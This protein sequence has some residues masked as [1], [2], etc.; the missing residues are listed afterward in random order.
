MFAALGVAPWLEDALRRVKIHEPT[1]IQRLAIPPALEGRNIIGTAK[2]GSGKT[3][4]Y[5]LPILQKLSKDP[6][7]VFCLVLSP[8]RELC[9]QISDQF[10]ALGKGCKINSV[11]VV[12]GRDQTQQELKISSRPHVVVATPGR[13]AEILRFDPEGLKKVFRN[14]QVVVFDEADRILTPTFEPELECILECLPPAS[15]RQTMLFSATMTESLRVLAEKQLTNVAIVDATNQDGLQANR[16]R[17][18]YMHLPSIVKRVYLHHLLHSMEPS[19]GVII[20]CSTVESTQ[21]ITTMCEMLGFQVACLHSLQSQ[22]RRMVSL[23]KF[24]GESVN[25]LIATDVA[26]RGLDIPA[27]QRVIN[28]ELPDGPD[29]YMHRVGRTARAGR[30]GEAITF[31]SE[32]DEQKIERIEER[33]ETKLELF[34]SKEEEVLKLM[35]KTTKAYQKAQLLLFEVGF[36]EKLKEWKEQKRR[37]RDA[38]REAA[39]EKD[40]IDDDDVDIGNDETDVPANGETGGRRKEKRKNKTIQNGA[41]KKSKIKN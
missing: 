12:G 16:L 38:R 25:I 19:H 14:I 15:R 36:D 23:L 34:P 13:L 27:V 37:T 40:Y 24:K 8:V 29:E 21:R 41:K 4:A 22:R 6:F 3:A 9:F 7:G 2:T 10:E 28:F 17:Q 26:A 20:F 32:G 11:V 33:I 39:A 30:F 35:T 31:V 5:A 18:Y 1:E